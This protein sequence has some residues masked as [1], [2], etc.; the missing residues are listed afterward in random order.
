MNLLPLYCAAQPD[1][2]LL[3]I[4]NGRLLR[5]GVGISLW[6]RP[7][8]VVVR[9]TSTVQRVSFSVNALSRERLQVLL[10]GFILWSVSPE[11][12]GPFRAFQ[13]LGVVNLDQPP[14]DLRSHRHLLSTP[15]HHAF[16]QLLS[17][18]VQRLVAT[19]SMNA[20]LEQQGAL[21]EELTEHLSALEAELGIRLERVEMLQVRPSD[22]DLLREMSGAARAESRRQELE[23]EQAH[24]LAMEANELEVSRAVQ[25]R[26]DLALQARL[27]RVRRE[28]EANRDAI[29]AVASAE[30]QKSAAVRDHELS[31]L[32]AE[33]VGDALKA[34]PLQEARWVTVGPQTPAAGLASLIETTRAAI[35]R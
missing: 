23:R 12:D 2:W 29:A 4:R 18:A 20:L 34:L 26:E 9:F 30:E 6:R 11:G 24:R 32:V 21:V 5:A 3:C 8:D 13:K 14:H 25:Q 16:Q 1:E 27:D 10:E 28:A 15:Q 31:R 22:Q 17:A 35:S 33:K 19:R 7:G